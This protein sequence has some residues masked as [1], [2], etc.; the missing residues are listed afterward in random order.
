MITAIT[1]KFVLRRP[2]TKRG[3]FGKLGLIDL[4]WPDR[5]L[6][7]LSQMKSLNFSRKKK[8]LTYYVS[9]LSLVDST[10]L[11]SLE[12][13]SRGGFCCT[14]CKASN[15]TSKTLKKPLNMIIH[16]R[17]TEQLSFPWYRLLSCTGR[18]PF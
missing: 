3:R 9:S 14:V 12:L 4:I 17:A 2:A 15:P 18:L 8:S 6:Y 1:D 7:N 10:K 5:S 11:E 13:S 16:V